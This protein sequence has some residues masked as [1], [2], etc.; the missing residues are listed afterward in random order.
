MDAIRHTLGGIH[1]AAKWFTDA[2]K[3][4]FKD[5]GPLSDVLKLT[6]NVSTIAQAIF[7]SSPLAQ[8]SKTLANIT[9]FISARGFTSRV[10]DLVSVGTNRR[11]GEVVWPHPLWV[12]NKVVGLIG[13][14]TSSVRWLTSISAFGQALSEKIRDLTVQIGS[15]RTFNVLKGV[16][17][18]SCI[19][20]SALDIADVARQAVENFHGGHGYVRNG[21]LM[22]KTIGE[23][24]LSVAGDIAKIAM[25]ILA[26]VPG[27]KPLFI[28]VAG[29]VGAISSLAKFLVS[30]YG[31]DPQAPAQVPVPV[32]N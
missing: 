29:S 20:S 14:I 22:M 13:D 7:L 3:E 23:H 28:A 32:G 27:V 30:K 15:S 31:N 16:G 9:D 19:T 6:Q 5:V 26:N 2:A 4:V 10:A 18:I 1:E 17:D 12:A 21:H 8:A 24:A 11:D 25:C